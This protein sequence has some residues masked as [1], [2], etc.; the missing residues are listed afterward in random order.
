MD[1]L[2]H[3]K[4]FRFVK[5]VI[6]LIRESE[7]HFLWELELPWHSLKQICSLHLFFFEMTDARNVWNLSLKERREKKNQFYCTKGNETC[8][9]SKAPIL[10]VSEDSY[11]TEFQIVCRLDKS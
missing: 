8:M 10:Q 7:S 11:R 4:N 9:L 6:I 3:D 2:A 1:T 5:V